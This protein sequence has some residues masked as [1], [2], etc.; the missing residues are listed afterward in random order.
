MHLPPTH[1]Q[2]AGRM[3]I[4]PTYLAQR[5]RTCMASPREYLLKANPLPA[6]NWADAKR[7]VF[8]SYRDWLRAVSLPLP[9]S[10]LTTVSAVL[11]GCRA[12]VDSTQAPEIQQ[13]YS[14]NMPVS[15]LRTKMRQ[16]YERHRY[17]G[18]LSVVDML[19]AQGAMEYQVR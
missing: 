7:R 15:A 3:V 12:N 13:M 1:L 5:T 2:T 17:V 14:L 9:N 11:D 10:T 4:N 18:Q 16:E 6:V 19:I 8:K